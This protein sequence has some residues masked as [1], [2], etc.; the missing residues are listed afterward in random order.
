MEAI[1]TSVSPIVS[2]KTNYFLLAVGHSPA[3]AP[4]FLHVLSAISRYNPAAH[5]T[6]FPVPDLLRHPPSLL[7]QAV[8][9]QAKVPP[10]TV[11][12]GKPVAANIAK[13][14]FASSARVAPFLGT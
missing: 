9:S 12:P 10:P 7:T 14:V 11:S 4:S 8:A 3:P 1:H 2:G 13:P 5:R 6:H